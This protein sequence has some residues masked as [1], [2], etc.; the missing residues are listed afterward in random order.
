MFIALSQVKEVRS[1]G[2]PCCAKQRY[3]RVAKRTYETNSALRTDTSHS[4]GARRQ[5]GFTAINMPLLRSEE[6]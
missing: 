6:R 1:V 2:V 4:C 5:I 3:R